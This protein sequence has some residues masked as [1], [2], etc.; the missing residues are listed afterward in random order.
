M[1]KGIFTVL[2]L[3]GFLTFF[4]VP[5]QADAAWQKTSGGTRYTIDQSPG[6]MVGLKKIDGKTYYFNKKGYMLTGWFRTGGR[7]FYFD[8]K[9]GI[10][11]T[12]RAVIGGKAYYFSPA[13]GV[14]QTGWFQAATSKLWYYSDQNGVMQ[15]SKWVDG[16]YLD[17]TG[18]RASGFTT[19]G[20]NRY[21]FVNGK[22]KTGWFSYNG[23]K[24]YAN[25]YGILQKNRWMGRFY[26]KSDSS[27][28][29]GWTKIGSKKYYFDPSTGV[30]VKNSF[31]T[32]NG[33]RFCTDSSGAMIAG[34]WIH[35]TYYVMNNGV[36]A[37]G[38]RTVGGNRYYFHSSTGAKVKGFIPYNGKTYYTDKTTGILVKSQWVGEKYIN[39]Y[40]V[41]VTNNWYLDYY[42]DKDGNRVT[43]WQTINGQ[44]FYFDP[45]DD[46]IVTGFQTIEGKKY[47]FRPKAESSYRKGSLVTNTTLTINGK[48]YT[49]NSSGVITKEEISSFGQEIVD[50]AMQFRG[51]PY[52]YGGN[53]LYTGVDCSGFTQQVM[54]HFGIRIPRTADAQ[55]KG[56]GTRIDVDLNDLLPGDLLFYGSS[57]YAGHVAL[58]IGNGKIIHAA[59]EQL[60][61]TVSNYNYRTPVKAMRYW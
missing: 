43:K 22:A 27:M 6:Y 14:L 38:W 3:A 34:K 60:G 51:Y 13:N 24:Y 21:F 41:V 50:Y 55:M 48:I 61:I 32:T 47:Y 36:V 39:R 30:I 12:G 8:L 49:I 10:M 59:N 15:K 35:N 26:V 37:T 19:I 46:Q 31:I 44:R 7:S 2:T 9:T 42:F 25:G 16:Y 5:S 11:K 29:L 57:S 58:Y 20:E 52:V 23:K 17:S 33:H 1:K 28:A 45:S 54:L 56:N 53:N 18:K 40:G 4:A